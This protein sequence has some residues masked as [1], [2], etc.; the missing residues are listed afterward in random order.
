MQPLFFSFLCYTIIPKKILRIYA[1]DGESVVDMNKN[2]RLFLMIAVSSLASQIS[3]NMFN[4]GFIVALSPLMMTVFLY[5]FKDLDS[6]RAGCLMAVFSPLLRLL[7]EVVRTEDFGSSFAYVFPD[8]GFFFGFTCC[9]VFMTKKLGYLPYHN[10][11][12]RIILCDF[13]GN[14]CE[15]T[16]RVMAGLTGYTLQSF[17]AFGIIAMIRGFIVILV[18]IAADTY[19]SLL[20]KKE[21]EENYKRLILMASTFESEVYSMRKNMNEIEDI[22]TNAFS[23]YRSLDSEEYPT[24]LRDTALMI[25]KDI[26]EVK[27]DY[28]RVIKGLQD[29]FLSDFTDDSRL[30]LSDLLKIISVDVENNKDIPQGKLS[31]RTSYE[32]NYVIQKHFAFMSIVRNFI[33]N[34]LDALEETNNPHWDLFV[35]CRDVKKQGVDYCAIEIKDNGPGIPEDVRDYIFVPGYSTKFDED[36]GDINRGVGLTLAKDLMENQF[37]GTIEVES[38]EKGTTFTLWF[39]VDELTARV[40]SFSE[41]E[42]NKQETEDENKAPEE[43]GALASQDEVLLGEEA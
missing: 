41:I 7:I 16:L 36:T 30:P 12:I 31:F 11:Y 14:C 2:A 19:M 27:K 21:H 37:S 34:S 4:S 35:R 43:D 39:P 25:A 32:S 1:F 40:N 18:C 33:T 20:E 26:H 22:M 3:L 28:R 8:V 38:S 24:E 29:N 15:Q 17:T 6:F 9:F 42:I 23:L 5:I 10:F 13:F